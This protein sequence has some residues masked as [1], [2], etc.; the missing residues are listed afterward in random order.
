MMTPS[1]LRGSFILENLPYAFLAA[2]HEKLTKRYNNLE[3]RYKKERELKDG[4]RMKWNEAKQKNEGDVANLKLTAEVKVS[5][6][7]EKMTKTIDDLKKK[8]TVAEKKAYQIE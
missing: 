6:A 4:F 3:D 8:L 5:K 1:F 7:K 2:E